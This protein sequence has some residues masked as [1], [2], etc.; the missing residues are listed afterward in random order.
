MID[1]M[2][3]RAYLRMLVVIHAKINICLSIQKLFS[4]NCER[5]AATLTK[6]LSPK[7]VV[8]MVICRASMAG[9]NLFYPVELFLG[10]NCFVGMMGYD[11][12]I[13]WDSGA[14]PGFAI[15]HFCFKACKTSK[16]DRIIE[17]FSNSP[18]TPRIEVTILNCWILR[19]SFVAL[20]VFVY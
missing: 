19:K 18:W 11:L 6:K 15:D 3:F 17:N 20:L 14:F 7:N 9:T 8:P 16:I 10:N 13:W 2:G 1:S 4:G 5:M 12:P